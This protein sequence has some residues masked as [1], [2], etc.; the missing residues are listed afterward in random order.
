MARNPLQPTATVASAVAPA[1]AALRGSGLR[2]RCH[3]RCAGRAHA[4][5]AGSGVRG[6][7]CWPC[8]G[9][10]RGCQASC[11]GPRRNSDCFHAFH[12]PPL[13]SPLKM[14]HKLYVNGLV[15]LQTH[16]GWPVP[17]GRTAAC[18][19]RCAV[20]TGSPPETAP[21]LAAGR[22]LRM[23]VGW[24]RMW[25]MLLPESFQRYAEDCP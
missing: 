16:A 14:L 17:A 13:R 5:L 4:C 19:R 23:P 3:L 25:R 10:R 7:C 9:H 21:G 11:R 12:F 2:H 8:Q 6:G 24:R 20:D 22:A 1:V 15:N 18:L